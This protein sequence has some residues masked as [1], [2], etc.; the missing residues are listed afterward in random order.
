MTSIPDANID[1]H[2]L[3]RKC[4]AGVVDGGCQLWT[5]LRGRDPQTGVEVDRWGCADGFVPLLLVEIAQM[6]RQ[7]GAAVESFRNE[8][9]KADE[10]A[11]LA[12]NQV[13]QIVKG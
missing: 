12:R 9:V 4:R 3:P 8:V 2:R 5:N 11:A 1:C 6:S 13:L 7:T 10:Q